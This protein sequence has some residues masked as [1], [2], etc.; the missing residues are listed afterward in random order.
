MHQLQN[1]QNKK[2]RDERKILALKD[3]IMEATKLLVGLDMGSPIIAEIKAKLE[4]K[5]SKQQE[6]QG[7]SYDVTNRKKKKKKELSEC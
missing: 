2:V 6:E 7:L 1:E 5:E 4:Q 3:S